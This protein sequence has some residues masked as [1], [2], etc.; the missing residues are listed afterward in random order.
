[1]SASSPSPPSRRQVLAWALY[2]C[3]NSAFATAVIAGFF[4][5]FFKEFWSAGADA[6][7]STF[8]LG[9]ANSVASLA[10][11]LVAPLL[12]ALADRGA[13]K[14]AFLAAFTLLGAAATAALAT[15]GSGGWP[16]AAVLYV[17]AGIGFAGA[18][19]FYDALILD[20]AAHDRLDAV[21]GLGYAVGYLGGGV[22]FAAC[23]AATLWP[24][25]FGLP[26]ASAAVRAS[27]VLTAL[28]WLAF[29]L[30]LLATVR[31]RADGP[32]LPAAQ[33]ARGA[34]TG[35]RAT[36]HDLRTRRPILMFLLGY[37]L[38]I[39]GV[40]TV[41]RMAVDY[42]LALGFEARDLIA[43]LLLTQFIGFPAALAFGWLGG[44]IGART[45]ILLALAIYAGVTIWAYFLT[46][47]WQ[48]YAIA[49]TIGLV[50]GGVQSLSRSL[51]ARLI[52]PASAAGYFAFYNLLGKFAAVIGPL[53]MGSVAA[54]TGDTRTSILS[55]LLLFGG[56]AWFLLRVDLASR[57]PERERR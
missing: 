37:W 8:R 2:D 6:T 22:F 9:L 5:V 57:P 52:P 25:A 12:G 51:Y 32:P 50:Q 40:D 49:A 21:S 44:R 24:A 46:A 19:I 13:L 23:V 43:A 45:G 38:Y 53:L 26:D 1:M 10:V 48:F 15:V 31:E 27:F 30:P 14:K 18:M 41:I 42:G 36:L 4:P 28:W 39:D 34:W 47:A 7:Q 35:F 17:A 33:A 16:A 56:G 11:L 54:L 3:G 55:L 29:S 20:V